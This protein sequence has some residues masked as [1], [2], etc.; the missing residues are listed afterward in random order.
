MLWGIY[1]FFQQFCP[2]VQPSGSAGK[3][4]RRH[5]WKFFPILPR[6]VDFCWIHRPHPS[7]DSIKILLSAPRSGFCRIHR[8]HSSADSIK[9]ILYADKSRSAQL[10]CAMN[11]VVRDCVKRLIHEPAYKNV[12][13][14]YCICHFQAK[15]LLSFIRKLPFPVFHMPYFAKPAKTSRNLAYKSK[16]FRLF[17]MPRP[18]FMCTIH[19]CC[20]EQGRRASLSCARQPSLASAFQGI[21]SGR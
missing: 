15:L 4:L 21:N 14:C 1:G 12:A 11:L 3:I 10:K 13:F 8:P 18:K 2:T 9:K 19:V 6:E 17:R 16:P 7:A 5:I 20:A